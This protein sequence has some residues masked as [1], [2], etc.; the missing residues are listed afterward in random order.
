MLT[1]NQI[2]SHGTCESL[3]STVLVDQDHADDDDDDDDED[4][5]SDDRLLPCT[6]NGKRYSVFAEIVDETQD[7]VME[8]KKTADEKMRILELLQ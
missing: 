8:V 7:D 4:D 3:S 1:R 6:R 5:Q 2:E